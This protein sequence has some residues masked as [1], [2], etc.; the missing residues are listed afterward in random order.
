LGPV[1]RRHCARRSR[2]VRAN[3]SVNLAAALATKLTVTFCYSIALTG[4]SDGAR[5][6]TT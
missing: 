4:H 3:S 6:K 2:L 1:A 5:E